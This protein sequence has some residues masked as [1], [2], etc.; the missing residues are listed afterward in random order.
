MSSQPEKINQEIARLRQ[1]V[2]Q[3]VQANWQ[4]H[5]GELPLEQ[6]AWAQPTAIAALNAK[7]HIAWA[8]GQQ[9]LWLS[10]QFQV[11]TDLQGYPLAGLSL[12]LGLT[13]WAEQTESFVN[14]QL[15]QAGDLFDCSARVLLS[16]SAQPGQTFWVAI[17]LVSP[18]HDQGALVR[19]QLIFESSTNLDPGFV[20]DEIEVLHGYL[21][22]FQP[23]DL[24]LLAAS[25][26]SLDWQNL[27]DR[28]GFDQSLQQVR[29]TLEP[30]APWLQQ[31]QIYLTGH[32]HLD[33]AWLWPVSETWQVAERTFQSVLDLQKDFP[34]LIFCHSS[35]ALYAWFEANRPELFAAIQAQVAAGQWEIVAGLWVE[36]ELNLI[37]GESLVRQV[38]YGQR[39]VQEKFGQISPI[40]WLPDSFGF[41]WQLPQ[42]LCQGGV[43]YFVT[44]KLRWNDTTQFPHDLFWWRSPDGSQILSLMSALIGESVNPV[45]MASYAQEWEAATRHK[46][47][48]WLPGV[49]DHGGG[50]TR[51]MLEIARRWQRSP[52]FPRLKFTTVTDYLD[53]LNAKIE[54]DAANALPVWNDELYLEFHRGCYT[55]RADQKRANRT[56]EILLYNAELFASLATLVADVPYPKTEIET[57]WKQTLF[58]QFH[59]IL[60]GSS[61]PQVFVDANREWTQAQQTGEQVLQEAIAAIANQIQFPEPPQPD[62]LPIVVFNSLNWQRSQIVSLDLPDDQPWQVLDPAEYPVRFAQQGNQLKFLAT[63]IPGVGYRQFWL[64]RLPELSTPGLPPLGFVLENNYLHV[65]IHPQTGEITNLYDTLDDRSVLTWPGN[66]L[67]FFED[68][69]QYWDAWNI[70]P[71]YA[72][73]PLPG[74]TLTNI[75]WAS[76]NDIERSIRVT[77]AFCQSQICQDYVLEVNAKALKIVTTVDWHEQHVL[78]KAA[79]PLSISAEEATYEM[80]CGAISRPTLPNPDLE[81]AQQAKWEVPALQWADLGQADGKYGVSLLNNCKYGYDAQ[82]QQLR[83]TLLRGSVWPD[84]EADT[85]EHEFTYAIYPHK[86]TWQTAQTVRQGYELNA[87]LQAVVCSLPDADTGDR[88]LPNRGQFLSLGAENLILMA[89]KLAE[90]Q[91]KQWILRCYEAHGEA[92]ELELQTDISLALIQPV[93]LL[94]QPLSEPTQ[95]VETSLRPWQIAS[96]L[97]NQSD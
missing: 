29:Q 74:A 79:F 72:N 24:D 83:L 39:Y 80:A 75:E 33:L 91:P 64:C 26:Q 12:R 57:A 48:L 58:N 85:G 41:C 32:A 9:V 82:P 93:D 8:A 34:E 18:G 92:A 73:H 81:P 20:A 37:S 68:K 95:P 28:L 2:Q 13:W 59:D 69:G 23:Q 38:L 61:I 97:I 78:L 70:D 36:P 71:D 94:E 6:A 4:W 87:P 77:Y 96:F 51:D 15:T 3:E 56:C 11:P 42:I 44:Q 1:L 43:K 52:L 76:W 27:G 50:P 30:F 25:L 60:P 14:G 90:D 7:N 65:E 86:G 67:Q 84:P 21:Q 31:R 46:E 19:S 53:L 66:Q 5:L 88:K 89:F 45:K 62:A 22:K 35:P 10:Q 47:S 63:E 49:G 16:E 40:A 17:R 54:K 55:S